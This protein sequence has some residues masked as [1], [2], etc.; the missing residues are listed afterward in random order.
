MTALEMADHMFAGLANNGQNS[1]ASTLMFDDKTL[2]IICVMTLRKGY[3]FY[4][5]NSD[6]LV[7]LEVVVVGVVRMNMA[8]SQGSKSA[9][10]CELVFFSQY[11]QTPHVVS[12]FVGYKYCLDLLH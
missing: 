8:I 1:H 11:P 3:Y 6:G 4:L 5:S 7:G 10:H 2:R 9:V 12:M